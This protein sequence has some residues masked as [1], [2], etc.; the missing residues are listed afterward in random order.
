MGRELVRALLVSL[1]PK[2]HFSCGESIAVADVSGIVSTGCDFTNG[3]SLSHIPA[4]GI[5]FLAKPANRISITTSHGHLW[6]AIDGR[7][8]S[9]RWGFPQKRDKGAAAPEVAD[10]L[11]PRSREN[12]PPQVSFRGNPWKIS[13]G[14]VFVDWA[15]RRCV[16]IGRTMLY[17]AITVV[18]L[19]GVSVVCSLIDWW[20]ARVT[21]KP[22]S[23]TM[24]SGGREAADPLSTECLAGRIARVTSAVAVGMLT[25]EVGIA[26]IR[27]M[28]GFPLAEVTGLA[29]AALGA[30][31]LAVAGT[32]WNPQARLPLAAF[33]VLGF[34]GIA[35]MDIARAFDPGL[36]FFWGSFPEWAALMMVAAFVGWGLPKLKRLPG[37]LGIPD[38]DSRWAVLWFTCAQAIVTVATSGAGLWVS[39]DFVFDGLGDDLTAVFLPGRGAACPSLLMLIGG[40]IL[41]TWQTSGRWRAFWQYAALAT[42]VLFTSSIGF[43]RIDA[44]S[45]DIWR[46]RGFAL[47]IS[48]GM[49]TLMT[50]FGLSR[51]AG[52][53]SDWGPRGRTVM[54]LF[55]A[56]FVLLGLTYL[57][58]SL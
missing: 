5:N 33:Y 57:L 44:A 21:E 40:T 7:A 3:N 52:R 10:R 25:V 32:L 51:I 41:M 48:T 30:T 16:T 1:F 11:D 42:G 20:G 37:R 53:T 47:M 9:G 26:F 38:Q 58:Q 14:K 39:L 45:T 28:I 56:L 2:H 18:F 50:G 29:R 6:L 19:S 17:W 15:G 22:T 13:P 46:D 8:M 12:V 23:E 31:V 35:M 43:A 4:A 34:I 54:P 36:Y 55:A 49:M 27:G 24:A